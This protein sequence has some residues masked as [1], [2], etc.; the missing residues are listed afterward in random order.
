MQDR[1]LQ[2]AELGIL[3]QY[4]EAYLYRRLGSD[5]VQGASGL[6]P[7]LLITLAKEWLAKERRRLVEMICPDPAVKKLRAEK[8]EDKAML[9]AAVA[10]AIS[11]SYQQPTVFTIAALLVKL[12]LTH[13][14]ETT[15]EDCG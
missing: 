8:I 13:L 1:K 7:E 11:A 12:G 2:L 4:E 10:D 5:L 14:C 6:D 15:D 3:T 9:A